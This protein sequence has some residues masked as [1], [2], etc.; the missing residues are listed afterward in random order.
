MNSV[1]RQAAD[2][3]IEIPELYWDLLLD[4]AVPLHDFTHSDGFQPKQ[5]QETPNQRAEEK[6]EVQP[7]PPGVQLPLA[8]FTP[9]P[10]TPLSMSQSKRKRGDSVV[11]FESPEAQASIG[12]KRTMRPKKKTKLVSESSS[13]TTATGDHP[14]QPNWPPLATNSIVQTAYN[15]SS[16]NIG[17]GWDALAFAHPQHRSRQHYPSPRPRM[18]PAQPQ[19]VAPRASVGE[20]KTSR[21]GKKTRLAPGNS[22][23]GITAVA[24]ASPSSL[25]P[26]AAYSSEESAT[27]SPPPSTAEDWAPPAFEPPQLHSQQRYPSIGSMAPTPPRSIVPSML[28]PTL[29]PPLHNPVEPF[30]MYYLP[31]HQ[32]QDYGHVSSPQEQAQETESF[33]RKYGYT[34]AHEGQEVVPV[35]Q[36]FENQTPSASEDDT[37]SLPTSDF[38]FIDPS[39][40]NSNPHFWTDGNLFEEEEL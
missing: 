19:F 31:T 38:P 14:L 6:Q 32:L 24:S 36:H 25:P 29:E 27:L 39:F 7:N 3:G 33:L 37:Q 2:L 21:P 4:E 8:S 17:E 22:I 1:V 9:A 30:G 11:D 18:S 40:L 5:N 28:E 35:G 16:P 23:M 20:K 10:F 13:T 12:E 15:S 26:V 34:F